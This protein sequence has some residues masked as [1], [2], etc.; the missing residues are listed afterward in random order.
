[1]EA[2]D[3]EELVAVVDAGDEAA[4]NRC[5]VVNPKGTQGKR[6]IV[7]EVYMQRSEPKDIKFKERAG[8]KTKLLQEIV[9]HELETQTIEDLQK[10]TTKELIRRNLKKEFNSALKTPSSPAPVGKIIFSKWIMQ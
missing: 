9:T 7:V 5:V 6:Y 1:M 10:P 2:D 8:K 3:P 4:A